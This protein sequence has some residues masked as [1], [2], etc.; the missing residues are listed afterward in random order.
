MDSCNILFLHK[1]KYLNFKHD[2]IER[3]CEIDLEESSD[4][5]PYAQSNITAAKTNR[6]LELLTNSLTTKDPKTWILVYKTY[7][8]LKLSLVILPGLPTGQ[9][10]FMS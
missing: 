10:T 9:K 2:C 7:L 5:K 3:E 8:R 1:F 6:L 4:L